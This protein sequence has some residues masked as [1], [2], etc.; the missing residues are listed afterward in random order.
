MDKIYCEK[1]I[2]KT[3]DLGIKARKGMCLK[4]LTTFIKGLP[5]RLVLLPGAV[6]IFVELKSK[7]KTPGKFQQLIH[8][9]LSELGFRVETIDSIPLLKEFLRS[10]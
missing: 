2:E 4:L 6:V 8:S 1:N 10:L 5:D 9:R 7:G 3:L